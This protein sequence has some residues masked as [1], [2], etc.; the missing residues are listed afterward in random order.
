MQ[1][2][3]V[4]LFDGVCNYCN[5]MVNFVIKQDKKKVFK[6]AA[7]QSDAAQELLKNHNLP[8]K[9]FNS[10]ILIANGS[11]YKSSTAGLTV[12]KKL[13]WYWKW[14][15]VFWIVPRFIRDAVYNVIAT[16]R[17]KWFGRKENCMI[18]SPQVKERFL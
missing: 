1:Q 17:Y 14:S 11:I 2:Q 5:S 9:D 16:N 3:P 4:I 13:S 18:P 8:T 15:Q 12:L 6:F 7:L 10:F